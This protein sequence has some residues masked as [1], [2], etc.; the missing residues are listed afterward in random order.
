MVSKISI[1]QYDMVSK[2]MLGISFKTTD[3]FGV[4]EFFSLYWGELMWFGET[5]MVWENQ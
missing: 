3:I 1:L 5:D 2:P 4:V